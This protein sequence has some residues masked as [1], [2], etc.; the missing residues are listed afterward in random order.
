MFESREKHRNQIEINYTM[1]LETLKDP[2]DRQMMKGFM[3]NLTR[4]CVDLI[5]QVL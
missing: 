2:Y 1:I 4:L 5:T 3:A